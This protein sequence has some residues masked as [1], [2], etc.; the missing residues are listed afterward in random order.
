MAYSEQQA[1]AFINGI[2]PLIV[3]EGTKRGY[4]IFSATIAQAIIEGAAGTSILASKYHNHFGMK[5]GKNWSGRAVNLKTKEE[6]ST[7]TLTDITAA[8]RAYDTDVEGVAGYYDFI[9]KNRYSNL[10]T[11]QNYRQFAEYLKADGYATSSTY[12]NTLCNT[13]QKYDLARYDM[14]T[15]PLKKKEILIG[16]ASKG[17]TGI[18]GQIAGNQTGTELNIKAYYKHKSGWRVFRA[19]MPKQQNDI[20]YAMLRAVKN[21]NIGYD[22]ANRGTLFTAAQKYAYDPG[23][24][25]I[26]VECDCSSLVRVCCAYAGIMLPDFNTASEA[27]VLTKAYFHEV[28]P[29]VNQDTGEGLCLGDILVTTVKGH[30]CVVVQV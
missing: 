15:E 27:D 20:A 19:A 3:K 23:E 18:K 30:T 16:Q 14:K 22:Q 5:C 4:R 10:K 9:S 25:K 24:V 2:A 12:V 1:R 17:E 29:R 13:V 6:Y 26:D 21:L 28:T 11:A 8:F 7:G